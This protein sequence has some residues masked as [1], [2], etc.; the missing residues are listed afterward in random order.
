M[1]GNVPQTFTINNVQSY[2]LP[3]SIDNTPV[4]FL[5]DTGTGVSLLSEEVWDRL[6]QT[7]TTLKPIVTQQNVGVDGIPI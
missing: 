4:S 2:V 5:V 3:C 1:A 7:E 6:N